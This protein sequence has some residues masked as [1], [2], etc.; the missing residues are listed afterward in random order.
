MFFAGSLVFSFVS[1]LALNG[2]KHDVI[3]ANWAVCGAIAGL[4][5]VFVR[6][7]VITVLRGSDVTSAQSGIRRFFLKTAIR[8]SDFV[9]C[10]SKSMAENLKESFPYAASKIRC[11]ENGVCSFDSLSSYSIRPIEAQPCLR[12]LFVGNLTLNKNT[13]VIVQA[14][15]LLNSKDLIL[16]IVGDGK[17]RERLETLVGRYGLSEQVRFH[18]RVRP[19]EVAR[20][21]KHSD[22]LV[23][24]SFS[25]GRSNVLLEAMSEGLCIVASNIVANTAVLGDEASKLIFSPESPKELAVHLK[26][27]LGDRTLLE[28]MKYASL[29]RARKSFSSWNG[30]AKKYDYLIR[31][32]LS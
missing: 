32:C 29:N 25:E 5:R 23:Q 12:L 1:F 21:Y 31:E 4:C 7:P 30:C 13:V 2:R 18:G 22:V 19:E 6:K 27:L 14:L 26:T 17:E 28:E 8:H 9:V 10:V 15:A 20:F 24:S 16:D 3:I 11:I